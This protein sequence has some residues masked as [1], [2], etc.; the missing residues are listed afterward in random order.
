M[1][2]P[3]V[4]PVMILIILL[5]ILFFTCQASLNDSFYFKRAY[6]DIYNSLN[7]GFDA[8]E[9]LYLMNA[10]T[11]YLSDPN[12]T[13]DKDLVQ[14]YV[15]ANQNISEIL[16]QSPNV[17]FKSV[18]VQNFV[19][20][21]AKN[22]VEFPDYFSSDGLF[23]FIKLFIAAG[24]REKC[25]LLR[26]ALNVSVTNLNDSQ[27]VEL[28]QIFKAHVNTD[29]FLISSKVFINT[30]LDTEYVVPFINDY[31]GLFFN[32]LP[33]D[34]SPIPFYPFTL[35]FFISMC[36]NRELADATR[37]LLFEGLIRSRSHYTDK[38]SIDHLIQAL[39]FALPIVKSN[40]KILK[41]VIDLIFCDNI[42]IFIDPFNLNLSYLKIMQ[43]CFLEA[44]EYYKIVINSL[45]IA[46][47]THLE[48]YIKRIKNYGTIL[49]CVN[50]LFDLNENSDELKFKY[51]LS[52]IS[53]LRKL[54]STCPQAFDIV[55]DIKPLIK[56]IYESM[57]KSLEKESSNQKKY[58]CI[59]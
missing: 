13:R 32:L 21:L 23:N 38:E 16:Y 28:L 56:S 57:D 14:E 43:T 9:F 49:F 7:Q 24:S 29:F 4:D 30:F 27:K 36:Y 8:S 11:G 2:T 17:D 20:N 52:S 47:F 40:P 34:D 55:S 44:S 48:I 54:Y 31:V 50:N 39:Y 5:S 58:F 45:H 59:P 10:N 46:V 25:I 26:S 18:S 22:V 6:K 51:S 19:E 37:E 42:I 41:R 53:N 33:K 35:I 12:F 1:R 15:R 3:P